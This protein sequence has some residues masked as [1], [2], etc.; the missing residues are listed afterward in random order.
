MNPRRKQRLFAVSSIG[1]L[2]V[3][4]IGFMLYALQ[5]SI[6]V[7]YTPTE[8]MQ[9]KQKTGQKPVLGQRL[10][11]GGLVVPGSVSRDE[12]TLAVSFDLMDTGPKVTVQFN[13]SLPDLFREGQ[14]IVATGIL[15]KE[16]LIVAHEVLAKHDEEYMP[17]ELAEQLKGIKHVKPEEAGY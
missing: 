4:S 12:A 6:D 13:G 1:V 15:E 7:F 17:P 16:N 10:R 2:L 8:I 3:L 11:I 14:G 9:G 5:D